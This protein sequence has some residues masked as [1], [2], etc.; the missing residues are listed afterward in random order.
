MIIYLTTINYEIIKSISPQFVKLCL[1]TLM[2]ISLSSINNEINSAVDE[3]EDTITSLLVPVRYIILL[4]FSA[5]DFLWAQ[6]GHKIEI[7][8]A[9]L[10]QIWGT[11]G[12]ESYL[13]HTCD[14]LGAQLGQ[15][16]LGTAGAHL[17]HSRGK[18][19]LKHSFLRN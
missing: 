1:I 11:V 10:G 8:G 5:T 7:P 12:A 19:D 4:I 15:K 6:L 18:N 16:Q 17:G 14:T 13:G 2:T 3:I 9:H